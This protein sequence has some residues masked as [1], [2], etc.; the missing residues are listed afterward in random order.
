MNLQVMIITLTI[1]HPKVSH[2]ISILKL[3]KWDMPGI[4]T[5]RLTHN[6][7][8][9]QIRFNKMEWMLWNLGQSLVHL[10]KWSKVIKIAI[11]KLD[12]QVDLKLGINNNFSNSKKQITSIYNN[13]STTQIKNSMITLFLSKIK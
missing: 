3:N 8:F 7:K 4:Q 1:C 11:P 13:T 2:I 5:V 12:W 10:L 9:E 6:F